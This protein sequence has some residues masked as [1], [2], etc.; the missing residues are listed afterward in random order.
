MIFEIRS[1]L[2]KPPKG[3]PRELWRVSRV[4]S[5]GLTDENSRKNLHS[6]QVAAT[7]A[8]CYLIIHR[9]LFGASLY[10]I[11]KVTHPLGHL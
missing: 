9:S 11:F 1:G 7:I 4:K 6:E 10:R 2:P 3:N 5:N 8:N